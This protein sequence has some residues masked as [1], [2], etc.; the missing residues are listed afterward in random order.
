MK[1]FIY[2]AL[3]SICCLEFA[4]ACSGDCVVCHPK[5]IK[6]NGKMDADHQ[7]L[8]QCKNCHIDGT[9][10]EIIDKNASE[11]T[12]SN[13]RI[14]KYKEDNL[15][16]NTSHTECGDDCWKCHDI[17]KVSRVKIKEHAVLKKCIECHVSIDKNLLKGGTPQT[18][19][20]LSDLLGKP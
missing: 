1:V 17:T 7:I 9:K 15:S 16:A 5:L 14:V 19:N 13:I 12:L 2:L 18:G 10:I 11:I 8:T 3:G 6:K 20:T 4:S